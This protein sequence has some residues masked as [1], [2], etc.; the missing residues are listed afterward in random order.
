M[1]NR[2]HMAEKLLLFLA[3]FLLAGC[4][5]P[6]LRPA[7]TAAP[8]ENTQR[9]TEDAQ[10]TSAAI[11]SPAPE[12]TAP[13]PETT[14]LLPPETTAPP[15]VETIEI[16]GGG[17]IDL[18]AG[19]PAIETE[20]VGQYA[21]SVLMYHLILEEPYTN[22][23][24]L[25]VR[26]SEF[27]EHLQVLSAA[28]CD[29]LFAGEY[30]GTEGRS[31]ILTF[32]DGYEDNYTEM[33]P[34]LKK[35]GAKATVFMIT[36]NI[37][38]PGYLTEDMIREMAASGL[39]RFESHTVS[40]PSLTSLSREGLQEQ[41]VGSAE[42]LCDLTGRYPTAICY[43]G[44]TVNDFVIG[45]AARYYTFGYTTVNSADTSGCN[46]LAIPRVRVSRGMSGAAV[47]SRLG[48]KSN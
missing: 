16:V 25:F 33:F 7:S 18:S 47:L 15:P 24:N 48:W 29:F 20:P 11:Q 1:K 28:G 22:L 12:T 34:I 35:Y 40:H 10:S 8:E 5:Q 26:P 23:T 43:P 42:R 37:N 21:P 13:I 32:D 4:A 46:P 36:A 19:P 3:A 17:Q 41:F 9:I 38:A 31:I 30:A 27:E 45:E 44:G 14:V 39:V 6:A 2:W